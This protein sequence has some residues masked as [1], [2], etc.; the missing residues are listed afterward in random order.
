MAHS[1]R[2][3][4]CESEENLGV[5]LRKLWKAES[6]YRESCLPFRLLVSHPTIPIFWGLSP[7]PM[8]NPKPAP[9]PFLDNRGVLLP[10]VWS[11]RVFG[12]LI[13]ALTIAYT[14]C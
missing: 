6:R 4:H 14:R 3:F 1:I 7:H 12:R 10:V 9:R 5:Y 2:R 8:E 13:A 11:S